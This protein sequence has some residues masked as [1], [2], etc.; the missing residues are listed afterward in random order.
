MKNK[1]FEVFVCLLLIGTFFVV[2]LASISAGDLVDG[3]YTYTVSGGVATITRYNG[4][5]GLITI[6]S[7]LGGYPTVHIG[8]YAFSNRDTLTSVTIPEGVTTIGT[9]AFGSCPSLTSVNLPDSVIT[10][11]DSAFK[12]THLTSITIPRNVTTIG[13]HTFHSCLF[14]TAINV[15]TANVN[16]V[17]VDGVLYNKSITTFV[18]CPGGTTG[19]F[20]ISSGITT[21]GSGAFHSC[22]SLTSVT[23]PDSVITIDG[24]AFNRCYSLTS[25]TIPNSVT[26]LGGGAFEECFNLTMVTIGSGVSEIGSVAFYKCSSLNSVTIGSSVINIGSET[27]YN[28]SSLKSIKFLGLVAPIGIGTNWI[29]N[30]PDEIR[31]HAYS[32]SNFPPPGETFNGL[33]MGAVI[34]SENAPPVADFS[35]A[36]STPKVNQTIT[37]DASASNDSDGSLTVYEWDW[38]NDGTYEDT[39]TTPTASHSWAQ[40]GNYSVM[41]RVTDNDGATNIKTISI[42]IGS[43]NQSPETKTPGF[44]LVVTIGAIALA[45]FLRRKKSM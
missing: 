29:E 35:W 45:L 14:L 12:D 41:V 21:I 16:Y 33:T 44:E 36:P 13:D 26:R 27:F 7:T 39:H 40:A 17:S 25:M 23:I 43:E 4:T 9:W 34:G 2:P 19:S 38:N 15:D 24:G 28:C 37:F 32:T 6:P 22:A 18:Q 11:G 1:V 8:D 42:P 10:I 31:G 3:D 20:T 5:S 30:T